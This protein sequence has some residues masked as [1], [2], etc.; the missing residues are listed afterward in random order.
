MFVE[1]ECDWYV[2]V[3]DP[4]HILELL[5]ECLT[6]N[7]SNS[8]VKVLSYG[9]GANSEMDWLHPLAR[10]FFTAYKTW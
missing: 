4:I 2:G 5:C 1:F 9:N 8:K 6:K 10:L 3:V 7:D